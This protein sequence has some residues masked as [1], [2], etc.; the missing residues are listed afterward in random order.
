MS[1]PIELLQNKDGK[2]SRTAL[3]FLVWMTWLM[4]I[5]GYVSIST[6]KVADLPEAYVYIT[7]V[8]AG[9]YTARRFLDGK[10]PEIAKINAPP[11]P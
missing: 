4:T 1:K 5:C 6:K 10:Y 3:M 2:L 7:L 8:L 11:T 9:T